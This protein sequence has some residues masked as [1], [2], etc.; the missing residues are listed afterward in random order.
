MR[1]ERTPDYRVGKHI[2]LVFDVFFLEWE[3]LVYFLVSQPS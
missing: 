3:G 2:L 1:C